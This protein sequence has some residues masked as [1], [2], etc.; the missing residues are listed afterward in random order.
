MDRRIV[1]A[2]IG[3]VVVVSGILVFFVIPPPEQTVFHY[4]RNLTA[5]NPRATLVQLFEVV[6]SEIVISFS[7]DSDLLYSV[8]IE[9]FEPMRPGDDFSW[10]DTQLAPLQHGD[11]NF[12]GLNVGTLSFGRLVE[13][14]KHLDVPVKRIDLTLG[15]SCNYTIMLKGKNMTTSIIYDNDVRLTGGRL[16]YEERGDEGGSLSLLMDTDVYVT[17]CDFW[18]YAWGA[19][20]ISIDIK[21]PSIL[22]GRV[23]VGGELAGVQL[24][25]WTQDGST[26]NWQFNRTAT[27]ELDIT[28]VAETVFVSLLTQS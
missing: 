11:G 4:G 3:V 12:I 23:G 7:N 17:G 14:F 2:G 8:D 28:V 1:A 16:Q 15:N 25:G 19:D 9:F 13:P 20:T 10:L 6:D 26:D 27:E 22:G 24:L 21:N 5:Y 18:A